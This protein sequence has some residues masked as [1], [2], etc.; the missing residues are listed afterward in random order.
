MPAPPTAD[1]DDY[2]YQAPT[3]VHADNSEFSQYKHKHSENNGHLPDEEEGNGLL[4][5]ADGLVRWALLLL[6]LHVPHAQGAGEMPPPLQFTGAA[7]NPDDEFE[8]AI[9]SL[10]NINDEWN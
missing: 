10:N 3:D 4:N 2:K 9:N 8:K 5:G 6:S 1:D 7:E